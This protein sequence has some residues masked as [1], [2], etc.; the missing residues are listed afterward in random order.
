MNMMGPPGTTSP[1]PLTPELAKK[2]EGVNGVDFAINRYI[3]MG[4][5]EFNNLQGFGFAMSMPEGEKRKN[6]E[7]T[8]NMKVSSGRLLKDGDGRKVVVGSSF[9]DNTLGF[10]RAMKV[11]DKILLNEISFEV[12]GIMEKKGSFMF[13]MAVVV[14]EDIL[15]KDLRQNGDDTVNIIAVKVKDVNQI[16]KVKADIEKV[17]RKERNVK[18]GE[19]DFTVESPKKVLETLNSSL[20][21]VKLFVVIIAAISLLVGGIGITN[22]MY[23]SVMERTK[24]IG[25]MKSIGAKN[26]TIFSLFALES[27]FLGMTGGI[28]GVVLGLIFAYGLAF[29]G[30]MILGSGL[31]QA[32]ATPFLLLASLAFSFFVGIIAGILPAMKASRMK[33][34]DSLRFVK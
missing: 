13:D 29:A 28:I 23:T 6:A 4:S 27:G 2:I 24:E 30:Q 19:E 17:L 21:A 9:G 1:N 25:I 12:V 7:E 5:L 26:K 16:D 31:I 14:N 20:F 18:L 33:P 11:G 32:K 10:K 22:T 3:A 34:V 15:L 8:I